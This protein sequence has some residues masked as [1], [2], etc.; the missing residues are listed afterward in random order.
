MILLKVIILLPTL[1]L[2][3]T[4]D[5][6]LKCLQNILVKHVI[7]TQQTHWSYIDT[8]AFCESRSR[9]GTKD[10]ECKSEIVI[11]SR[12]QHSKLQI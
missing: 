9:L 12:Y 4:E 10:F 3:N 7:P 11:Q 5:Q 8:T 6:L 1:C 2:S